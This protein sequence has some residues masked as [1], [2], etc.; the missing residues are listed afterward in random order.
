MFRD[1]VA[2][3]PYDQ[4]PDRKYDY[5]HVSLM[6]SK[7]IE[8]RAQTLRIAKEQGVEVVEVGLWHGPELVSLVLTS[9]AAEPKV[10]AR[11]L[12]RASD[13]ILMSAQDLGGSMEF[14]H[15]VGIRLAH[16]MEREHGIG[17]E[18]MRRFK[19][20]VDPLG[21]MNPGKAGL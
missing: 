8:F 11:R 2:N 13:R 21:I 7:V 10:A 16:L 3:E 15:G 12:W 1:R 19:R 17:L 18:V 9:K 5:I 14:C 4:E 20:T 6:A